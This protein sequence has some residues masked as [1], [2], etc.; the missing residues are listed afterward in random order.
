MKKKL[1]RIAALSLSLSILGTGL[2]QAQDTAA[3]T[4]ETIAAQQTDVA[5]FASFGDWLVR[6]EAITVSRNACRLVQ[7]LSLRDSGELVARFIVLPAPEGGAVL[8]ERLQK[9]PHLQALPGE[10]GNLKR[11]PGLRRSPQTQLKRK[12]GET[13]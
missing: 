5:N 11:E 10:I 3:P 9:V 13:V 1:T 7:E 6:C 8:P 12:G 4:T 2:A